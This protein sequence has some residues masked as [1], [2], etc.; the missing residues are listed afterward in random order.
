MKKTVMVEEI[1]YF[2]DVCGKDITDQ[3]INICEIC[4]R[5]H[6]DS[7]HWVVKGTKNMLTGVCSKCSDKYDKFK[8]KIDICYEKYNALYEAKVNIIHNEWKK[9][10]L[11]CT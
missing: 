10:S 4:G 6:C 7:C 9:E 8:Q 1:I 2:C 11:D 5:E 3:N